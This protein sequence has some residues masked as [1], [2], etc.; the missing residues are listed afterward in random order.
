MWPVPA[1]DDRRTVREVAVSLRP[2]GTDPRRFVLV[3]GAEGEHW[4][5]LVVPSDLAAFCAEHEIPLPS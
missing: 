1:A 4:F 5:A 2:S 3:G